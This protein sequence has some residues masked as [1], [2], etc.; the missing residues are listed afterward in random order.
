MRENAACNYPGQL[1]IKY[2]RG[3]RRP[4]LGHA[5]LCGRL[6]FCAFTAPIPKP[7]DPLPTPKY[8]QSPAM[9]RIGQS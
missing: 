7:P 4:L 2:N 8:M 6:C 3:G 9:R 5:H 1:H